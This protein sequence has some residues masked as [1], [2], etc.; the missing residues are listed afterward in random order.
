MHQPIATQV[1]AV[2]TTCVLLI[3]SVKGITWLSSSNAHIQRNIR[4]YLNGVTANYIEG[5]QRSI[6]HSARRGA[7]R[8]IPASYSGSSAF[9]S[10]LGDWLL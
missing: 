8:G 5:L 6:S 4:G 3:Y 7:I 2:Q 10:P 9:R 1:G